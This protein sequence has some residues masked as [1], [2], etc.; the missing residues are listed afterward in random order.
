MN[1][2][3]ILKLGVVPY[4][5]AR[6]YTWFP[7]GRRALI[8]GRSTI[9]YIYGPEEMKSLLKQHSIPDHSLEYVTIPKKKTKTERRFPDDMLEDEQSKQM[10]ENEIEYWIKTKHIKHLD[11]FLKEAPP[12]KTIQFLEHIVDRAM[13]LKKRRNMKLRVQPNELDNKIDNSWDEIIPKRFEQFEVE[14]R[15][16]LIEERKTIVTTLEKEHY[17][18]IQDN[19][20]KQSNSHSRYHL[21]RN[22]DKKVAANIE[23]LQIGKKMVVNPEALENKTFKFFSTRFISHR[24]QLGP[25]DESLIENDP[26]P[27]MNQ[28][29]QVH[30]QLNSNQVKVFVQS[31][32]SN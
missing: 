31:T 27:Q 13:T 20:I 30:C 24:E 32:K 11:T 18:K 5:S 22:Q 2:Y 26:T 17:T 12:Q 6:K 16:K 15:N 14:Y 29:L 23:V 1:E 7:R 21:K 10:I 28:K 19:Y 9:D 8:H 25:L 3:L 4:T